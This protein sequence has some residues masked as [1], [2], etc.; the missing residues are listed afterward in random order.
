MNVDNVSKSHVSGAVLPGVTVTESWLMILRVFLGRA[1]RPVNVF[2][3]R[4]IGSPTT[5]SC[6]ACRQPR[7]SSQSAVWV[8]WVQATAAVNSHAGHHMPMYVYHQSFALHSSQQTSTYFNPLMPTVA[9]WVQLLSERVK[10]SF[11]I[12]D[13]WAL[14]WSAPSVRVPGYQKLQMTA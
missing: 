8:L 9:I 6:T 11:V 2:N 3:C 14:W 10:Q 7:L 4:L 5:L 1:V 12:F 13:I